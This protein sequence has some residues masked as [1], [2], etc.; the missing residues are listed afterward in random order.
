MDFVYGAELVLMDD[1]FLDL[2]SDIKVFLAGGA[3][4][5]CI[6]NGGGIDSLYDHL[7]KRFINV[8]IKKFKGMRHE[9]Q[10]DQ[11]KDE[12]LTLMESFIINE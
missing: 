9:I 5:P 11:C 3:D 7:Q 12:L 4:D 8:S 10:N 6:V 2:N 1:T